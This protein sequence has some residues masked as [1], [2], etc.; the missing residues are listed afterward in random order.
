MGAPKNEQSTIV[1][2]GKST[3]RRSDIYI[4]SGYEI[5]MLAPDGWS[6]NKMRGQ[7]D[8]LAAEEAEQLDE[9]ATSP[10]VIDVSEHKT[11]RIPS[12]KWRELINVAA[13]RARDAISCATSKRNGH[14]TLA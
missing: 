2:W 7:R 14:R 1:P 8:K 10:K 12:K 3:T 5:Q 11:R 9:T 6:S 4:R 13:R